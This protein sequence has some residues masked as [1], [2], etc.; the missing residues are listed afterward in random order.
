MARLTRGS[1]PGPGSPFRLSHSPLPPSA[2][3][4]PPCRNALRLAGAEKW[5]RIPKLTKPRIS[6]R[7]RLFRRY[8]IEGASDRSHGGRGRPRGRAQPR[9]PRR[10]PRYRSRARKYPGAGYPCL[11][12]EPAGAR[13]RYPRTPSRRRI[14]PDPCP[15]AVPD[16]SWTVSDLQREG[17]K[18]SA[19][20]RGLPAPVCRNRPRSVGR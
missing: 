10:V 6:A 20:C 3:E 9:F 2:G 18:R 14:F 15:R 16:R 12:G 13:S 19:V 17:G 4:L 5:C 1:A 8:P 11:R 7:F